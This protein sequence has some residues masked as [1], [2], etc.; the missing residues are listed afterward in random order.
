[1]HTFL[2]AC[3]EWRHVAIHEVLHR[4]VRICRISRVVNVNSPGVLHAVCYVVLAASRRSQI[5]VVVWQVLKPAN[6]TGCIFPR[7]VRVLSRGLKV[8]SPTW[9]SGLRTLGQTE[10]DCEK[11]GDE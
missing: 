11:T 1:M 3:L 5:A 8:P 4:D 9:L 2:D 6:K 10:R 7:Q